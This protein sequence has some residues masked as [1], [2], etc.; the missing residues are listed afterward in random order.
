ML[1]SVLKEKELYEDKL[2][3]DPK[4]YKLSKESKDKNSYF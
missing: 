4:K 1:K 2:L 3:A